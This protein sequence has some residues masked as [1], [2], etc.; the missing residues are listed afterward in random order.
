MFILTSCVLIW[1]KQQGPRFAAVHCGTYWEVWRAL[2][3]WGLELSCLALDMPDGM[4]PKFPL[5]SDKF[6]EG[7]SKAF[8][9]NG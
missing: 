9:P 1:T 4:N 3:V 2:S 8:Q 5:K 6:K 7:R